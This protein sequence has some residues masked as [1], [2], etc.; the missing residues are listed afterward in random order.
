MS[1]SYSDLLLF[2][3]VAGL[4]VNYAV[5][6]I[7]GWHR[8]WLFWPVQALNLVVGAWLF[9]VGIPELRDTAD[10]G[11]KMLGLLFFFHIVTNNKRLQKQRRQDRGTQ[12]A[13]DA[14][15]AEIRAALRAAE[16]SDDD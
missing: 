6:R 12:A 15:R 10:I 7:P 1:L 13:D 14:R 4:A 3:A 8:P 9:G 2:G 11:N 16:P 5:L